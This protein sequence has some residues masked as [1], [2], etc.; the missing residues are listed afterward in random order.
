MRLPNCEL[1]NLEVEGGVRKTRA[2]GIRE[3]RGRGRKPG[4][5]HAE[6]R[7]RHGAGA[8]ACHGLHLEYGSGEAEEDEGEEHALRQQHHALRQAGVAV[9]VTQLQ[10]RG[11]VCAAAVDADASCHALHVEEDEGGCT[12]HEQEGQRHDRAFQERVGTEEKQLVPVEANSHG[13]QQQQSDHLARCEAKK[14]QHLQ[15]S[16]GGK[17]AFRRHALERTGA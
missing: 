4:V 15:Q 6:Q 7:L 17:Q 14:R 13:E 1:N 10:L 8:V 2:A 12:Q 5:G 9:I 11:I 3:G 16:V